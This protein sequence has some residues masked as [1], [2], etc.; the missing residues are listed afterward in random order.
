[1]SSEQTVLSKA[2]KDRFSYILLSGFC[3]IPKEN[4]NN[5]V[6]SDVLTVVTMKTTVFW[7]S[8]TCGLVDPYQHFGVM[9]CLHL[10]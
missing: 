3:S 5:L 6:R 8:T 10:Q 4:G 7:G 1:M 2:I 9:C